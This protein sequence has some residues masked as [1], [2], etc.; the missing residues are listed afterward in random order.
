[1]NVDNHPRSWSIVRNVRL[2]TA[3]PWVSSHSIPRARSEREGIREEA[4]KVARLNPSDEVQVCCKGTHVNLF[5][6]QSSVNWAC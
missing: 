2:K 3:I 1:M 6:S 4:W 5:I